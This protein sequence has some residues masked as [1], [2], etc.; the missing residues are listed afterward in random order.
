MRAGDGGGRE[1]REREKREE[2]RGERNKDTTD[3][4]QPL[5]IKRQSDKVK[6]AGGKGSRGRERGER[7]GY[8]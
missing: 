4:A 8:H 7:K 1:G 5:I 3:G 2:R 6:E